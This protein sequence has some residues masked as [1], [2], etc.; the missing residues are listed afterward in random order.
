LS[1]EQAERGTGRQKVELPRGL[2]CRHCG[3]R[4]LRVLYTRQRPRSI[5]RVR[6]CRHC[7]RRV[8]TRET[9]G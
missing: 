7:G 8:V 2:E 5:M 9:A 1:L 3:C 4:D 6:V